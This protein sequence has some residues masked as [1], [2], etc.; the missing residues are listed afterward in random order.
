MCGRCLLE[1]RGVWRQVDLLAEGTE[2]AD[3]GV[4]AG[5]RFYRVLECL[6]YDGVELAQF[7]VACVRVGRRG[8]IR[9]FLFRQLMPNPWKVQC[10]GAGWRLR[11]RRDPSLVAVLEFAEAFSE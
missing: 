10:P 4:F 3:F 5:A 6:R 11:G 2:H 9:L 1:P 7:E 8:V